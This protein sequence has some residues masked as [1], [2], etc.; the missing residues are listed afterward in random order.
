MSDR[1]PQEEQPSLELPSIGG[2]R[3]KRR[4][5]R[6]AEPSAGEQATVLPPEPVADTPPPAN[7]GEQATIV[8][9]E[10]VAHTP[11]EGPRRIPLKA[12]PSGGPM[13]VAASGLVVGLAVVGLTWASLRTCEQVQGT[14]SC[15][16]AGYPMLT[17]VLALAVVVGSVLLRLARVPDPVS[18]SV[19]GVGL[20]AVL[21]LLFLIDHLDQPTM[22][23]VIP[24]ISAVTF[25]AAHWVTTTFIEPGGR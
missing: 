6:A 14:S 9:P 13:V 19:L 16:T 21:A 5:K 8:L 10:P 11:P 25:A 15:G 3:R 7:G 1:E 4:S 17:F 22:I 12:R 23:V 2:W 24:V 20:A 18:T